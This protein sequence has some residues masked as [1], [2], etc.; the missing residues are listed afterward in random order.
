MDHTIHVLAFGE[1]S[2]MWPLPLH[3][4]FFFQEEGERAGVRGQKVLPPKVWESEMLKD[5]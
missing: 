2:Y 5:I 3:P 1:L 4:V